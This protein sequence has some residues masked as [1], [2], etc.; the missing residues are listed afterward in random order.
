MLN[1]REVLE[2][3]IFVGNTNRSQRFVGKGGN[4]SFG[5]MLTNAFIK[6]I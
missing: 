1:L 3:D 5:D 4:R 6:P 2:L